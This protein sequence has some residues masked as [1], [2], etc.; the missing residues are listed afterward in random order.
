MHFPIAQWIAN[1]CFKQ[2][3]HKVV[4]TSLVDAHLANRRP[5]R[6]THIPRFAPASGNFNATAVAILFGEV[7]GHSAC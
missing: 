4:Q 3:K 5:A 7:Y 1:A 2:G 6:A